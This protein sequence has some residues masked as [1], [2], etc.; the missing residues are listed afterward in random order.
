MTFARTL[1]ALGVFLVGAAFVLDFMMASDATLQRLVLIL[2][3][4]P[5]AILVLSAAAAV[6]WKDMRSTRNASIH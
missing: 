3:T 1:L 2:A 5:G 6:M 4:L